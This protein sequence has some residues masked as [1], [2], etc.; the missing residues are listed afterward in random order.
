MTAVVAELP[1]LQVAFAPSMDPGVSTGLP[2]LA[3]Q[4]VERVFPGAEPAGR[5]GPFSLYRS[6]EWL[7]GAAT[8]PTGGIMELATRELYAALFAMTRGLNLARVWHYVPAINRPEAGGLEVYRAF[9]RGRSVA[10][11]AEFGRDFHRVVP[12][13]SAVGTDAARLTLVFA[14]TARAPR[15]V[16]NPGQVPAYDYPAEYG[17]RPPSFARATVVP[18]A[19]GRVD[20]FIS[21]T[22]AIRGHATVA[23]DATLPQLACTIG[24][25]REI[26]AA[27]GAGPDLACGRAQARHFKVYLRCAVDRPSV[28]EALERELL[29]PTDAVSYLR[30][31]I[32]RRELDVEIEA[33]LLGA[34]PD[35]GPLRD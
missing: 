21:G 18:A 7:L 2:V 25:L 24:N 33:T 8:V 17:P 30:S 12:A 6:D 31:D 19:D 4:A 32:C 26:S 23:P 29:A 16:E 14:A 5:A 35:R 13:A 27:C 28:Q 10:F 11:E 1:A 20:V 3:G 15:H 34:V 9:S 22:A